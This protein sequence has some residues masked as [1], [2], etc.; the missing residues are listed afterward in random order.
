MT[1]GANLPPVVQ[2]GEPGPVIPQ[3]APAYAETSP[4]LPME[5]EKTPSDAA[6]EFLPGAPA[7]SK[8]CSS[9]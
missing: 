8:P 1:V 6:A 4:P 7:R 9:Y 2:A 3:A 5:Y